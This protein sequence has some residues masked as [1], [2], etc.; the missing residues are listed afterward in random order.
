MLSFTISPQSNLY[1]FIAAQIVHVLI[2]CYSNKSSN[3]HILGSKKEI[4]PNL[5]YVARSLS[6]QMSNIVSNTYALIMFVHMSATIS[7]ETKELILCIVN[8]IYSLI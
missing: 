5:I 3:F 4:Q 2:Q 6:F 7:Q 8:F 1:F